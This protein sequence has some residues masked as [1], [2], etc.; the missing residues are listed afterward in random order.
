M[1]ECV[2]WGEGGKGWGDVGPDLSRRPAFSEDESSQPKGGGN[3]VGWTFDNGYL[4]LH[5][6]N[7][8]GAV[9]KAIPS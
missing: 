1:K 2:D 9:F 5:M 3:K 6:Y 7:I 8:L 4:W